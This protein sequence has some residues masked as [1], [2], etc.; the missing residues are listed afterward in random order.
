M[1]RPR[2][3]VGPVGVTPKSGIVTTSKCFLSGKACSICSSKYVKRFRNVG[4]STPWTQSFTPISNVAKLG[5]EFANFG[6]SRS[7][8]S[9]VVQPVTDGLDTR[10]TCNPWEFKCCVSNA[11]HDSFGDAPSPHE[12]ESPMTA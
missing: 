7:I 1:F 6:N 5:L 3:Y 9:L 10:S 12:Y 4:S 11:G 8:A 2:A